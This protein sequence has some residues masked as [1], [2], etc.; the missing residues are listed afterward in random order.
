MT[1]FMDAT[2]S[3]VRSADGTTIA[4]EQSGAGPA[5]ILVDPAGRYRDFGSHRPLAKLLA[6]NF[7]VFTYDRRGRGDSTDTLPFAVER[8]VDDL[9]ALIDATGGPAFVYG[10][11]SGALLSLHAAASGLAIPKLALFEPPIATDEDKPGKPDLTTELAELVADG[12]RVEAVERFHTAIGVPAEMV[13]GMR[14]TPAW[15]ALEAIAHTLVYDCTIADATSLELVASVTTPTLVIDSEGTTGQLTGW[16]AAVVDALPRGTHRS[17]VGQWH[18]VPD[19]DLAP[20]LTE[21][22]QD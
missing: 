8:E 17:L 3:S 9:A 4:F 2:V 11:S 1:T 15:P 10:V 19:E 21:Y 20:V 6:A 7:T 14:Q 18:S 22:F 13:A 16:A 5:L 12:R